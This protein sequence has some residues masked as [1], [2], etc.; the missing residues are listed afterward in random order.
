MFLLVK[1]H[2]VV[3]STTFECGVRKCAGIESS[4]QKNPLQRN[5]QSAKFLPRIVPHPVFIG[6]WRGVARPPERNEVSS[7]TQFRRKYRG[8]KDVPIGGK[9]DEEAASLSRSWYEFWL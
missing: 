1:V 9:E 5:S 7:E 4:I 2:Q 3:D 6:L 8:T